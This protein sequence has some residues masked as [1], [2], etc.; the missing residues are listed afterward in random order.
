MGVPA[1]AEVAFSDLTSGRLR[2]T[3]F[4]VP[5]GAGRDAVFA[6]ARLHFAA[7]AYLAR[8]KGMSRARGAMVQRALGV[9]PAFRASR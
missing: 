6:D 5:A 8:F 9:K 2:M 4:I 7:A 3:S 1:G